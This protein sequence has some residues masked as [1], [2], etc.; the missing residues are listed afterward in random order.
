MSL[1][2]PFPFIWKETERKKKSLHFLYLTLFCNFVKNIV[3]WA[4]EKWHGVSTIAEYDEKGK[5]KT[6][7][8]EQ[9]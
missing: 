9:S 2:R 7:W 3:L 5:K 8:K 6:K 1:K 4:K